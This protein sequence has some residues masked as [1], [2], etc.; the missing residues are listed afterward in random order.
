[1]LHAYFFIY[2]LTHVVC[3]VAL[4]S[5]MRLGHTAVLEGCGGCGHNWPQKTK[6]L[7]SLD[8]STFFLL[9]LSILYINT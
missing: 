7:Y 1:M 8:A 2:S 4:L 3:T 5:L 9:N 6:G